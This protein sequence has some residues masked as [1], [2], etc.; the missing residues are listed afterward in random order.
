VEQFPPTW[1]EQIHRLKQT[2]QKLLESVAELHRHVSDSDPADITAR[3]A[4]LREVVNYVDQSATQLVGLVHAFLRLQDEAIRQTRAQTL[5]EVQDALD[6]ALQ[7]L[8]AQQ[9]PVSKSV[10][11][12]EEP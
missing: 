1:Q 8:A 11:T 7:R 5:R 4:S 3:L 12:G 6:A 10:E 9:G 2:E